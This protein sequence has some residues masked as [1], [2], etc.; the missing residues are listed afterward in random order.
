MRFEYRDSIH[1][2]ILSADGR[3]VVAVVNTRDT[4]NTSPMRYERVLSGP[5]E[6]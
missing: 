4:V 1:Q 5:V 2:L 6:H 3:T